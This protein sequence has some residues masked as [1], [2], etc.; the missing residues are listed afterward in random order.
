MFGILHMV[1]PSFEAC[2]IKNLGQ[3]GMLQGVR[4]TSN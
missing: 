1:Q 2:K 4:Y 3:S